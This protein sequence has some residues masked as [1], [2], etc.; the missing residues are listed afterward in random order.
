MSEEQL[1]AF[2]EAVQ[3][4]TSLQEKLKAATDADS[5]VSIAKEAG[6]EITA[7][8]VKAAT[9]AAQGD[10]SEEQLEGVAG[11]GGIPGASLFGA[12]LKGFFHNGI[13]WL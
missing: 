10:L 11:G 5:I 12:F 8:E 1:K 7:D 6:F 9:D 3:A 4:D 13:P 2:C